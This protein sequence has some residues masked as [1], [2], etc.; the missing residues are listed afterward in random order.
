[1]TTALSPRRA[2]KRAQIS[3]AARKLFLAQGFAA[4]S[5]DAVTAE[6]AVSKQTLYAYF[7]T[8]IDLLG[9]A[10]LNGISQL[11]MDPPDLDRM[12]T[13]ED[14]RR[15]LV[16]FSVRLTANLLQP[17]SIALVRLVLGE[18][19]RVPELR[20]GFREALPGQVLDRT[21]KLLRYS[22]ELDLIRL[23]DPELS[24]RMYVGSMMTYIALDGFLSVEPS[25][26]P[27]RAELEKLVDVFLTTVTRS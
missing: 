6:A 23:D 13:L 16:E 2:A 12:R 24:A 27:P 8:K 10:I 15:N 5:M 20:S 11:V 9:D 26:P 19:F 22:A 7:P 4:T 18:V 1:M 25:G 3:A 17:E 14:L 21:E